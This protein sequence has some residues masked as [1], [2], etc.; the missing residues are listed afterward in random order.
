KSYTAATQPWKGMRDV[1]GGSPV[2]QFHATT[3]ARDDA[4]RVSDRNDIDA[5]RLLGREEACP[6]AGG[7]YDI[8][9]E[10]DDEEHDHDPVPTPDGTPASEWFRT[11]CDGKGI[12]F[13]VAHSYLEDYVVENTDYDELPCGGDTC[14]AVTQW[15]NVPRKKDDDGNTEVSYDVVHAT[16]QMSYV[17]GLV[18][19]SNLVFDERPDFSVDMSQDRVRQAVTAYLQ[20][21]GSPIRSYEG[22]ITAWNNGQVAQGTVEEA[23]EYEPDREWY[24]NDPD[25][26]TLAPAL[27]R[28]LYRTQ[29][30][31]ER[32]RRRGKVPYNPPRLDKDARDEEGWDRVYVTVVLDDDNNLTN[33]RQTPDLGT[34]PRC[35][36]GLDAHPSMPMWQLNAVPWITREEIL[37]SEERRLWRR[38][39]RGLHVVQIGE[40][41]RP[42]SGDRAKEW[43]SEDKLEVLFRHLKDEYGD[44]FGTAITTAQVEN[45]VEEIM[46]DVGVEDPDLM[47]YGKEKSRNDFGDEEVG[48]V[49]GAMDPGDGYILD[50]IAELGL[51]ARPERSD[52]DCDTCDGSGCHVCDNTGR[53]RAAGRGFVGDDAE[54]ARE[55]LASVREN[56]VA[57]AAGR[58]ARN[59]DDPDD[60]AVV[61]VRTDATPVDFVDEI[62]PGARVFGDKQKE[63]AE[64]L[65]DNPR[66]TAREIADA[67][68][69]SKRHVLETLKELAEEEVVGVREGA[70]DYG[71]N[72][73]RWESKDDAISGLAEIETTNSDV[74]DSNTWEFV[75]L[76]ASAAKTERIFSTS[77]PSTGDPG[78]NRQLTEFSGG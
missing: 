59:P 7:E 69:V 56:H 29:A 50:V 25:A 1:T 43:L 73:Y 20:Q 31:G 17:P 21:A 77:N 23:L 44:G 26:H 4:F 10:A 68:D 60:T 47:H 74:R 52:V 48:F 67:V 14:T 35:V 8:D 32:G 55:I 24:F 11:M 3:D 65:R 66:S 72:S 53:K 34:T 58:Y 6:V 5:T 13:S 2:I 38:Y 19:D 45:E 22:L 75:I 64:F 51:D 12:P 41:T 62:V 70:A 37:N 40:A 71:A 30:D 46:E 27:A 42:L 18:A 33:I 63:I 57:Q 61:F 54:T 15:E 49:N 36:I 76:D 28:A 9:P 78:N 16:H 39:E